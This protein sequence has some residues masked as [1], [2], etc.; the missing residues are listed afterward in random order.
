[1]NMTRI[2]Q[3]AQNR[4]MAQDIVSRVPGKEQDSRCTFAVAK[5][6]LLNGRVFRNG[7]RLEPK[8]KS[9][10]CGVYHIWYQPV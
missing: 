10:G 3:N 2:A 1:M 6:V 9:L 7:D 8:I 4:K 5:Q